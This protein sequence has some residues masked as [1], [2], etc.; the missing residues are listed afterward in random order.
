LTRNEVDITSTP[1]EHNTQTSPINTTSEDTHLDKVIDPSS[2][3]TPTPDIDKTNLNNTDNSTQANS[4][5]VDSDY[6]QETPS[7]INYQCFSESSPPDKDYYNK[8]RKKSK[9]RNRSTL[10]T[11]WLHVKHFY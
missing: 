7:S 1:V 11:K 8:I 9:R 6:T 2:I 5:C 4:E 10:N 3:F